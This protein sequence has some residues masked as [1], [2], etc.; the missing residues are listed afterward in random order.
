MRGASVHWKLLAIRL[1]HNLPASP[2]NE[3]IPIPT[4]KRV[5]AMKGAGQGAS[6]RR[7]PLHSVTK[8]VIFV[9][10]R[11]SHATILR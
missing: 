1:L 10:T 7:I 4:G 3:G 11:K 5:G 6:Q 9:H 2:H 8:A